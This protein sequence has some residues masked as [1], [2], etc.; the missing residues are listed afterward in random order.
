MDWTFH[1]WLYLL[2][3]SSVN[4]LKEEN[5]FYENNFTNPPK[6]LCGKNI[7]GD[8]EWK[9]DEKNLNHKTFAANG[10]VFKNV[11]RE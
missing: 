8:D 10:E 6:K 4:G 1:C 5:V 7:C 3:L 2:L 11:C 9:L